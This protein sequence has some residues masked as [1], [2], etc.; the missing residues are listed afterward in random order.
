MADGWYFRF[1]CGT[2]VGPCAT[3][4]AATDAAELLEATR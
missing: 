1:P 4:Q 2:S 3:E